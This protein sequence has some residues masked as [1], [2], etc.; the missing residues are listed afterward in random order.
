MFRK[1][2]FRSL[3]RCELYIALL[4]LLVSVAFVV[5]PLLSLVGLPLSMSLS[6]AVMS[7]GLEG[8]FYVS[9]L[10]FSALPF[11]Y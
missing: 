1:D 2:N 10:G 3:E 9:L 7:A 6:I 4:L 8:L 11:L 5:P